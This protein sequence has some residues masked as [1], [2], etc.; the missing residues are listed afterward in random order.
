[1]KLGAQ[2]GALMLASSLLLGCSA[3]FSP[4]F[5]RDGVVNGLDECSDT[6]SGSVVDAQGCALPNTVQTEQDQAEMPRYL[7]P[8]VDTVHIKVRQ[9][10]LQEDPFEP[11]V[12]T[13]VDISDECAPFV[14]VI[15]FKVVGLKPIRFATNEWKLDKALI[16]QLDCIAAATNESGLSLEI[17]GNTDTV[18]SAAYNK[19][20]SAKRAKSAVEYLVSKGVDATILEPVANGFD[21]PVAD[22]DTE[23]QRSQNRRVDFVIKNQTSP[24]MP[25]TAPVAVESTDELFDELSDDEASGW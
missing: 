21:N 17:Q 20:L 24:A 9:P 18:G 6:T 15:D 8:I 23:A 14:D 25:K 11:I 12:E 3:S 4:D 16:D 5:D 2:Y 10:M 13:L 7:A 22:N 19:E 1:M